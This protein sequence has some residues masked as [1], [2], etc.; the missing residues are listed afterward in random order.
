[1]AFNLDSITSGICVRPPRIILL[2]EPKVGKSTM[3]SQAPNPI[4]IP[5]AKED[6][7]DSIECAQFPV[8]NS[9]ADVMSC[10]GTLYTENH[11]HQ[12]VVIDS[13]SALEPLVWSAVCQRSGP[14]NSIEKVGGG[15]GKGYAFALDEWRQL[16]EGLDALR[17][18]KTMA[19]ILTGH[20][21]VRRYDDPLEG[22]YDRHEWDIHTKAESFLYRW[23]DAVLFAAFKTV[24]F[25][26]DVGFN[27]EKKRGID[28]SSGQRFLYTQRRP[29]HPGG[30]RGSWGK[31]PYELPLDW[32][33]LA[34]A[35]NV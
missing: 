31:L 14:V 22:S 33:S 30:G 2:G 4:F 15:Y 21:K 20:T 10:L 27:K 1:M 29:G 8:S 9:F 28:T 19:C 26:E 12:T 32:N 25:R 7:L 13:A 17:D 35:L 5:I 11:E 18:K 16:A 24:V 6:G 23:A 34:G 3:A